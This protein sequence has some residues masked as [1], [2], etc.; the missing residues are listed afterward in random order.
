MDDAI[1]Y[2]LCD[3]SCSGSG[4]ASRLLDDAAIEAGDATP[5][6]DN[7]ANGSSCEGSGRGNGGGDSRKRKHVGG[8]G[9]G[10]GGGGKKKRGAAWGGSNST[11]GRPI[12]PIIKPAASPAELHAADRADNR[13]QLLAKFQHE[14]V[15]HAMEFPSVKF[16][17]YSTCSV[18][19]EE[20]EGVVE[21]V[22]AAHPE[23]ELANS[24]EQWPHRGI[25]ATATTTAGGSGSKV[26]FAFQNGDCDR[27]DSCNF[28]H[29]AGVGAE[30]C[31]FNL[32][33]VVRTEPNRDHATGMF[34]ALFR[35][36]GGA[37][38]KVVA[39]GTA[40]S[41]GND[42]TSGAT[43][44]E[45]PGGEGSDPLTKKKKKKKKKSKKKKKK[46]KNETKE[47]VARANEGGGGVSVDVRSVGDA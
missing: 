3:P 8:N 17:S 18:H 16:V 27:G 7:S 11:N 47:Q 10:G 42:N 22:L 43:A 40:G 39:A 2:V 23:F 13:L 35:R 31:S 32:E 1:R 15:T 6:G 46:N 44:T 25:A 45:V 5:D 26:C 20:N 34:V 9:G 38:R 12:V 19:H 41:S 37:G 29:A 30:G 24:V 28:S 4:I 21:S 14:V 36:K 33:H